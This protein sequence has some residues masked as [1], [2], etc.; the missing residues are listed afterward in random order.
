MQ[1]YEERITFGDVLTDISYG[2]EPVIPLRLD[3]FQPSDPG[4]RIVLASSSMSPTLSELSYSIQRAVKGTPGIGL[5]A[6]PIDA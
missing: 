4:L 5:S 2:L 1:E 6:Y 3:S